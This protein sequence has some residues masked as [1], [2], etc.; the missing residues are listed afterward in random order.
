MNDIIRYRAIGASFYGI[1]QNDRD[2][3]ID[4]TYCTWT[5]TQ[6]EY[7]LI[8][9]SLPVGLLLLDITNGDVHK[10]VCKRVPHGHRHITEKESYGTELAQTD[11]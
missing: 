9:Q 4:F 8:N 3:L 2:D 11:L 7:D 6:L 5:Q 1:K 10:V